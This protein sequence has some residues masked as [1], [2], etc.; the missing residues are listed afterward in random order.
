MVSDAPDTTAAQQDGCKER[1]ERLVSAM[2]E[3]ECIPFI[4]AGVS[5]SA[6]G[7]RPCDPGMDGSLGKMPHGASL[8]I[9]LALQV[10]ADCRSTAGTVD[11]NWWAFVRS[12]AGGLRRDPEPCA[13]PSFSEDEP[14]FYAT[15]TALESG[16]S[17]NE[18]L[19]RQV[20][21]LVQVSSPLATLSE[22]VAQRHGY[23]FLCEILAIHE[24]TKLQ[25]TMAHHALARL[26]LERAFREVITSNYDQC[27]E[28]A[29]GAALGNQPPAWDQTVDVVDCAQTYMGRGVGSP[30]RRQ[31]VRYYKIN[32]CAASWRRSRGDGE[33]DKEEAAKRILLTER[34][35]QTFRRERWAEGMFRDRARNCHLVFSGFGSEEPQVRH[36]VLAIAQEFETYA[37]YGSHGGD[38]C[39]YG[40]APWVQAH[41][42]S[43][44]FF[45]MQVLR[46]WEHAW[47]QEPQRA[48]AEPFRPPR[49]QFLGSDKGFFHIEVGDG[50][51]ADSFWLAL[52]HAWWRGKFEQAWHTG[53]GSN[54]GGSDEGP[55]ARDLLRALAREFDQGDADWR[56]WRKVLKDCVERTTRVLFGD[57]ENAPR[58]K[59]QM[60]NQC[61]ESPL[62]PMA[63][64]S[65][66]VRAPGY[67]PFAEEPE[68]LALALILLAGID[69]DC[70][71]RVVEI[72]HET[73]H[74]KWSTQS[75][76]E[77]TVVIDLSPWRGERSERVEGEDGVSF[78][79]LPAMGL[80]LQA[81]MGIWKDG[82]PILRTDR[83][84]LSMKARLEF[85]PTWRDVSFLEHR[86]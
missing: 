82:H 64:L 69:G 14:G 9:K 77:R 63:R 41:T 5:R 33:C 26:L 20:D 37:G 35:L 21:A 70:N 11:T 76:D 53:D 85:Q 46:A 40:A 67:L 80:M 61:G 15:L 55:L 39:D 47:G 32:G 62:E 56:G 73:L 31:R 65:K 17:D 45:Q 52:L 78:V 7:L 6:I 36:T 23:E 12:V 2:V 29:I 8:F 25:P 13:V 24:F 49:N 75:P 86:E 38:C 1:F 83:A 10:L 18:T 68:M 4:G 48:I 79:R 27:L 16:S 81:F 59:L 57:P 19:M 66:L 3:G 50:L 22:L 30:S 60:V 54:S 42:E 74:L 28:K 58:L 72:D 84:I 51:T 34:Q 71:L 44:S 43:L